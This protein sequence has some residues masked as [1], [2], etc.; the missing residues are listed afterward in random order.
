[1]VRGAMIQLLTVTAI[2]FAVPDRNL[3][4]GDIDASQLD[5]QM[6][7]VS[8][9][10]AR[11]I[12]DPT[13]V[14]E[15][16]SLQS[17]VDYFHKRKQLVPDEL[18]PAP[19]INPPELRRHVRRPAIYR[20]MSLA[21]IRQLVAQYDALVHH[22]DIVN[23]PAQ[24]PASAQ[25]SHLQKVEREAL[26]QI[27]DEIRH[28]RI[29]L[30]EG[31]T[32]KDLSHLE[33]L[34]KEKLGNLGIGGDRAKRKQLADHLKKFSPLWRTRPLVEEFSAAKKALQDATEGVRGSGGPSTV[35]VYR[36]HREESGPIGGALA[37]RKL[38][39]NR[40]K[41]GD[42][43]ITVRHRDY[44]YVRMINAA[45]VK[46]AK[47]THVHDGEW[48]LF[49]NAAAQPCLGKSDY[50]YLFQLDGLDPTVASNLYV[51]LKDILTRSGSTK[52]GPYTFEGPLREL[53]TEI[54]L[55]TSYLDPFG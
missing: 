46:N 25:L 3:A 21:Q 29:D 23:T 47:K 51:Q 4:F 1:M 13:D 11:G 34:A 10:A 42:D 26:K 33:Q 27:N 17:A 6:F 20:E 53:V 49:R 44:M 40:R 48:V 9:D 15:L 41:A 7:V 16:L 14:R 35:W 2:L 31:Y 39:D 32:V 30:V 55:P 38:P 22:K 18:R 12:G 50:Q 5:N 24:V 52:G 28:R 37:A 43:H 19:E 54:P 45:G 36:V 8:R